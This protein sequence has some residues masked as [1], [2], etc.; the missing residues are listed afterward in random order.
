VGAN[1]TYQLGGGAGT[2]YRLDLYKN[3]VV[4]AS[5]NMAMPN[6]GFAA[7]ATAGRWSSEVDLI[8]GVDTY[9]VHAVFVSGAQIVI[10]VS[11]L[12][13]GYEVL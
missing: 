8:S 7:N 10:G 2:V 12:N 1:T 6:A 4:A 13:L 9:G 11:C 3:G 5:F